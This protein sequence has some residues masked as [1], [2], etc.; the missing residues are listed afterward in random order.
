MNLTL[1]NEFR[2]ING[3]FV[4]DNSRKIYN[5]TISK[6][7]RFYNYMKKHFINERVEGMT[8]EII[9][10]IIIQDPDKSFFHEN[11]TLNKCW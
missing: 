6:G 3:K 2:F 10:E 7:D 8:Q 4:S 11:L 1:Y 9:D 5:I